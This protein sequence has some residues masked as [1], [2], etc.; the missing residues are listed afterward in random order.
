MATQFFSSS[1][2]GERRISRQMPHN[3]ASLECAAARGVGGAT[4]EEAAGG[5]PADGKGESVIVFIYRSRPVNHKTLSCLS[6]VNE[7]KHCLIHF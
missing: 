4:E 5:V 1:V 7:W 6:V 2:A 3:S